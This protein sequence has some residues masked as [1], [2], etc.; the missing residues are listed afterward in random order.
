M[1]VF[2]IEDA[3]HAEWQGEFQ[4]IDDALAE[5]RRRADIAWDTAPNRP[6]CTGWQTCRRGYVDW[7]GKR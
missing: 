3:S 2:V 4:R 5:L 7:M 1:A 6:P